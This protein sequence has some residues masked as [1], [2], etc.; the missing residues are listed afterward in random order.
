[1][2]RKFVILCIIVLLGLANYGLQIVEYYDSYVSL[3]YLRSQGVEFHCVQ[4]SIIGKPPRAIDII[5]P[6]FKC[7]KTIEEVRNWLSDTR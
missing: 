4:K 7:F 2:K 1:M 5:F 3:H 6:Y